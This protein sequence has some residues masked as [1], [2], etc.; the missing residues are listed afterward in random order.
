MDTNDVNLP[1]GGFFPEEQVD[2][3]IKDITLFEN[4]IALKSARSAFNFLIKYLKVKKVY[5]PFY[6][7]EVMMEPIKLN[8]IEYE[9]YAIDKNFAPI[10]DKSINKEEYFLY[11]NYF[12]I[13][14]DEVKNIYK[15][16]RHQLIL[17]NTHAFFADKKMANYSFNSARKFFGV[18]DGAFLYMKSSK[19]NSFNIS[20]PKKESPKSHLIHLRQGKREVAFEEY[21]QAESVMDAEIEQIS[22]YS[23]NLL[24]KIDYDFVQKQRIKN[25]NVLASKLK[26]YNLIEV[27]ESKSEVPFAYPFLPKMQLE[28]DQLISKGIFFPRLWP[29]VL[30]E[31]IKGFS[32]EKKLAQDMFP[33]PIDHRWSEHDMNYIVSVIIKEI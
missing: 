17:D 22:T 33:L 18:S 31:S 24:N 20:V 9:Y 1:I 12:G 7:C 4:T 23:T 32:F 14:G 13:K 10:F 15:K 11:I 29:N 6:I 26:G 19:S 21:R 3:F 2:G 28:R 30:E 8:N 16:Y 5:I 25:F 27:K